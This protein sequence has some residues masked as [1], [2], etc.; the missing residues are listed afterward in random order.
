MAIKFTDLHEP[1]APVAWRL[2][3]ED[4]IVVLI[5]FS[6]IPGRFVVDSLRC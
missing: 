5:V 4:D 2:L 6:S 3:L 1:I